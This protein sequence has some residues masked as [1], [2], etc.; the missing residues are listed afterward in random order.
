MWVIHATLTWLQTTN[1]WLKSHYESL[2]I[3]VAL[4]N[5]LATLA[6][7]GVALFL[8]YLRESW[9][10][11]ILRLTFRQ[12]DFT[13]EKDPDSE[14]EVH[15]YRLHVVN[16]G[17]QAAEAV[18]AT[19]VDVYKRV[20]LGHYRI[21]RE[22]LPTPLRWTHSKTALR[23]FLPGKTSRLLD[24]G[25]F[26]YVP[27]SEGI[28]YSFRFQ[29]EIDPVSAYNFLGW[30]A[31]VVRVV[32]SARNAGAATILLRLGIGKAMHR[33]KGIE[34]ENDAAYFSIALADNTVVEFLDDGDNVF[35]ENIPTLS[36]WKERWN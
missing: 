3:L 33:E 29:T 19:V 10:R 9:V 35:D 2:S 34:H 1:A 20:R 17:N 36:T 21:V 28:S 23:V 15:W 4:L 31:Y 13:I 11:P 24:F 12:R 27:T 30:G 26:S 18:E 7:V 25:S 22:F 6:A 32:V 16:D 5:A 14:N 8:Q